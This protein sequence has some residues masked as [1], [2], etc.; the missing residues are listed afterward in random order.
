MSWPFKTRAAATDAPPQPRFTVESMRS[1][2][3]DLYSDL[4]RTAVDD[5]DSLLRMGDMDRAKRLADSAANLAD[6]A[7]DAFGTRWGD[8][9]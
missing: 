7:I 6:A 3:W 4:L 5:A 2:W 8:P 1:C 9:R